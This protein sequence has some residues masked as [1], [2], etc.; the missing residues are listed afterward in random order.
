[1]AANW[2]QFIIEVARWFD[3]N[4]KQ[5]TFSETA[6]TINN[7]YIKAIRTSQISSI[8]G[9]KLLKL[10]E[11]QLIKIGIEKSLNET[12]DSSP[13]RVNISAYSDWARETITFW[14]TS[15]WAPLPPPPGYVSP[16]VGNTVISGGNFNVL[17]LGLWN[18][19]NNPPVGTKMGIIIATKLSQSFIQHFATINGVYSGNIA[20][21]AGPVPGP[22]FNWV[23]LV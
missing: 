21:T 23:G 18:A 14:K 8:P 7:A 22:P 19:F 17:R 6:T 9:S 4:S 13:K 3:D 5:K 12:L 2:N 11:T 15:T 10:G 1:M 20:S 16:I